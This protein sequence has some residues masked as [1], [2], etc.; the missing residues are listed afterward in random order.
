MCALLCRFLNLGLSRSFS[1]IFS[2]IFKLFPH[3]LIA[4]KILTAICHSP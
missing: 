1:V 3:L 2:S 4:A